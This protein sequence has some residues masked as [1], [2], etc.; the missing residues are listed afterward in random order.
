MD[1]VT[2]PK[3]SLEFLKDLKNNNHRDWFEEHRKSFKKEQKSVNQFFEDLFRML[4]THDELDTYKAF[5]IYRDVRF[6]KNKTPYKTH[7]AA[8]FHRT[9]PR[10]RGGYYL[11]IE[12]GNSFLAA[13]F[14]KPEKDDLF[15]I[16]KEFEF[17]DAPMR[18][19]LESDTF[20]KMFN[21]LEGE[22]LKTAPKGFEKE[23]PAID[24]I[25]KKQYIVT[26]KFTD[27]QVVSKGFMDE[28]NTSFMAIRPWFD[29]MSEV[30]TTD[31]NGVS[32]VD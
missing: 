3:S 8:S 23:H 26:R 21:G 29:Y 25:R 11:H 5:R 19:H 28:V 1:P 30:L 27:K 7:L 18:K 22:E 10:K 14:W 13:G 31:L 2:I 15:R 17:D 16:R 24:L 20:K 4:N 12:P 6:S 32:L 9:K